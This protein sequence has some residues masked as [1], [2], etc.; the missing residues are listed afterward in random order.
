MEK[1]KTLVWGHR[2]A[3]AYAPENTLESFELASKMGADGIELDVR[4][5]SDR[6]IVIAH[7]EKIDRISNGRGPIPDYTLAELKQFD[8]GYTFHKE[9]LTGTRIATLDEVYDLLAPLDM[10]VNVE[11]KI[12]DPEIVRACDEAALRHG[13]RD[14]IIYSSFNH[15]QVRRAKEQI[16]N[17]FVAPLHNLSLV[18]VG[19]YCLALGA[20]AAHP[21]VEA[22]R[23]APDYV[24]DC[25][26][27]G[28]RVHPWTANTPEDIR[29]LLDLGV[30]A[31]ITN[32]PDVAIQLRD[33][34]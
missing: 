29:F 1:V 33:K 21:S 24:E 30:D 13:M 22:L 7:D 15:Y 14:R 20:K 26:K 9:K 28:I 3:S 32:F 19:D 4:F 31:I 25:H 2:G 11:I 6:Q 27:K 8:F 34:K 18:N 17:A 16:P 10:T 12:P 5:T 23:Y